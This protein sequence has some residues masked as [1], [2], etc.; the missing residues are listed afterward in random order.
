MTGCYL[1]L[2]S[3]YSYKLKALQEKSNFRTETSLRIC[4]Q[5]IFNINVTEPPAE[6][7]TNLH[8]FVM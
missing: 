7:H 3:V 6:L 8:V 4:A 1:A 5:F 2:F